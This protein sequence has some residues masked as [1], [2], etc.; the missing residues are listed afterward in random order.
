VAAVAL[1]PGDDGVRL[2]AALR[3]RA[4]DVL[5]RLPDSNG[6]EWAQHS[7]AQQRVRH[8]RKKKRAADRV[9]TTYVPRGT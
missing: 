8:V 4:Q 6:F 1:D 5:H 3:A 2:R 9:E 7:T